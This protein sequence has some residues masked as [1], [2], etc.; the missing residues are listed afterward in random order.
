MTGNR[1]LQM[2]IVPMHVRALGLYM[3]FTFIMGVATTGGLQ[4]V[5]PQIMEDFDVSVTTAVWITIA[6]S[7]ALSG[8][9]L[10]LGGLST[11][12]ERRRLVII[13]LVADIILLVVIFFTQNIYVFIVSRFLSA[14]F[15]V[16][17]WLILQVEG[18][19][20]FPPEERG[21]AVGYTVLTQG[22]GMMAALPFT[23]FVMDVVGWRWLFMGSAVAYTLMIPIVLKL[24]PKLPPTGEKKPLSE[25]DL[26]G[27]VLMVSG[28]I[29]FV[30]ALQL[31]SRGL[32]AG[33]EVLLLAGI[34]VASL[35][36][37]VWVELRARA[38]ILQISLFRIPGVSLSAAQG[39]VMGFTQGAFMLLLP[40]LFIQ[41]VGWSA[42]YVSSILFFQ[43]LTRPIAGP[44]AGR[45]ADRFGTAAVILPA[46]LVS[47]AGQIGLAS[48]GVSPVVQIAVATLAFW[49]TGQAV[50]QTAN[51]RQ[52]YAALPRNVLHIAPS[53]NLVVMTFG[54]T[55]G[56]AFGSLAVEKGQQATTTGG[57]FVA[58][59]SDAM[60]LIS[61]FFGIAMVVTQV[62]P[63]LF[64]RNQ[65]EAASA[66]AANAVR[67]GDDPPAPRRGD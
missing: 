25:F 66:T 52:I 35:A 49:G 37:F 28:M 58:Y 22:L 33:T 45:L 3:A 62:L 32:G 16:F 15:R 44:V 57:E 21:K 14:A 9:T 50:M 47:V 61:I 11:L 13:G 23:G 36:L 60:V 34:G 26:A 30:T 63:R 6:Y 19:G 10:A 53:L 51:I 7:V 64:F 38:P 56:Q 43:H 8:G 5:L 55:S 12:F 54:T 24:L 27:S 65:I 39:V 48:L 59:L 46:A 31:Y 20:G 40:F 29:C 41:G 18:I 1:M 4:I 67:A 17:P 42:A 2:P